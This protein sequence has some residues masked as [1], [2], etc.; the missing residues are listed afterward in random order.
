M[1]HVSLG[2]VNQSSQRESHASIKDSK[3]WL[4]EENFI[5]MKSCIVADPEPN[6]GNVC[7]LDEWLLK[8]TS[9]SD[10]VFLWLSDRKCFEITDHQAHINPKQGPHLLIPEI[11]LLCNPKIWY[12]FPHQ[13]TSTTAY[14]LFCDYR[15]IIYFYTGQANPCSGYHHLYLVQ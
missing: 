9:L 14:L 15:N 4:V 11:S 7:P 5:I 13:H 6:Y 1:D 12:F 3:T 2:I 8:P 10:L